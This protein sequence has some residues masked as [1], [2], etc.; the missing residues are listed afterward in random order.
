M[1]TAARFNEKWMPEPNTGCWLWIGNVADMTAKGRR[2]R[3]GSP[4]ES[5]PGAKLSAAQVEEIR[6]RLT[7]GAQQ[8]DL[9]PA[10]GVS[11]SAI[12]R[13]STGRNWSKGV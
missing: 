3:K 6:R 13:I 10:F 5:H 4:G 2:V 9:A 11:V 12:N 7:R 8:I 1:V